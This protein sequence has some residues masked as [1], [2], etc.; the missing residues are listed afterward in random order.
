[1]LYVPA[2]RPANVTFPL[3]STNLIVSVFPF[4]VILTVPVALD[5]T[6]TFT[7]MSC[8]TLTDSTKI[9]RFA[10]SATTSKSAR[11]VE[12]SWFASVTV[13][14]FNVYE[15]A[16]RPVESTTITLSSTVKSLTFS[17]PL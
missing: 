6:D 3:A 14:T 9:L 7:S 1:M 8:P 5:V 16:S 4:K 11:A 13:V 12:A 15:P 2:S 17:S 10:K